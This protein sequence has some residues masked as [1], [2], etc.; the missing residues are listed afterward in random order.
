[1]SPYEIWKDIFAT[2]GP[3]IDAALAGF[4]ERLQ[5]LRGQFRTQA[6]EK[7]FDRAGAAAKALR[8]EGR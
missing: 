3:S 4:I 5:D 7:E 1:M 2:N 6:I 8:S